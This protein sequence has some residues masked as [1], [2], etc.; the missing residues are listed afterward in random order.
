MQ[1]FNVSEQK[2][3]N[4]KIA[5]NCNELQSAKHML[6][7]YFPATLKS[8]MGTDR[9][10]NEHCEHIKQSR[11]DVAQKRSEI[12]VSGQRIDKSVA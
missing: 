7:T 9:T 2:K 4:R 8:A 1:V 12:R 11:T 5:R 3:H 6:A 10:P